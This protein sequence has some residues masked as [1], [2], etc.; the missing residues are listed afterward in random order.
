MMVVT[1]DH[2]LLETQGDPA[3]RPP[4]SSPGRRGKPRLGRE[5]TPTQVLQPYCNRANTYWYTLDKVIPPDH[6]KPPK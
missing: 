4:R 6:R 5:V 3:L 2:K 1:A